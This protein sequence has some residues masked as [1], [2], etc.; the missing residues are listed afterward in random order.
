MLQKIWR[1][2]DEMDRRGVCIFGLS[3]AGRSRLFD[4]RGTLVASAQSSVEAPKGIMD[5]GKL[6]GGPP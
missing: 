2:N 1:A 3:L 6:L 5:P 4:R